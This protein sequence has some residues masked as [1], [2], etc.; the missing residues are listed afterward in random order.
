MSLLKKHMGS[1][2]PTLFK[3]FTCPFRDKRLLNKHNMKPHMRS[4]HM[5]FQRSQ[6]PTANNIERKK[7]IHWRN[8]FTFKRFDVCLF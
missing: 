7:E 6:L 1:F 8:S 4:E 2:M 5:V 3:D